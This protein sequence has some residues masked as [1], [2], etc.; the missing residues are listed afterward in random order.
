MKESKYNF[1]ISD[2]ND[3]IY[4]I[5]NA[6]KNSLINDNDRR[7]QDF[8][9]QSNGDIKY[10]PDFLTEDEFCD[11]VSSGFIVSNE[12]DE[13]QIAIDINKKRL[14]V[15][16]KK[17]KKMSL[18][19]APSLRCNF[20]CYYCYES[21]DIRKNEET[22]SIEVQSDIISF[23]SKSITKNNIKTVNITWYGGEPL[24]QSTTI[25]PMQKK[26]NEICNAYDVK[27]TSDIITNGILLTPEIFN[28]L[29]EMGIK[30]A[31]ITIDGPEHIHNKRRYYPADPKNNYNIILENIFNSNDNIH[32]DI[33]INI[34]K[35]NKDFIFNLIEDLIK[36]KIWPYKK[37]VSI[38]IAKVQSDN[39]TCYYFSKKEFVI[40]QDIVRRFLMDKYNEIT[41]TNKAKLNFHYPTFGGEVKCGY[42]VFKNSWVI[43]YNGDVFRCWDPL[44]HKEHAIGTIKD[45]LN[46]Y[47]KFIFDKIK[48][49][50]TT[51]QR[52]GCFDCK[53]FPIC[54]TT[55]PWDFL[56]GGEERKCSSWKFVLEHRLLSQYKTYLKEPEVYKNI[57]FN[58]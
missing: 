20:R 48:L 42:A 37:N 43:S 51:F 3:N 46:N 21:T 6:L 7:I 9:K 26:I 23:I 28:Q 16:N 56:S 44:G 57:P 18:V 8:I 10:S 32:F 45:L 12:I 40:F 34:D 14:S 2:K 36:R 31:Q 47:G 17:D 1:Y 11:L 24:I 41:K 15:L 33:R 25:F 58:V 27:V 55:C 39:N 50:N 53:I 29:S 30:R 22:M 13:K 19:I 49:K 52:M 5:Y 4:L 35:T 38:Y 54:G